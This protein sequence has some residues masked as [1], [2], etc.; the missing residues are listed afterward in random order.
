M[1]RSRR[2]SLGIALVL[3]GLIAALI[4]ATPAIATST[5]RA[6]HPRTSAGMAQDV[7]GGVVLFGGLEFNNAL[8]DT[9]RWD[10]RGWTALHPAHSPS[11]RISMGMAYDAADGR[12]VLFGGRVGSQGLGDTWTW[13]GADW[14]QRLGGSLRLAPRSG[15]AG[16]T[17][18]IQGWG[19]AARERVQLRFLDSVQGNTL[20]STL[21]SDGTG[22]FAATVTIP[23]GA[24]LGKQRVKARGV[25]SGQIAKAPYRVK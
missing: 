23:A 6:P 3:T 19:F 18:L 13:D 20:L 14:T 24:T 10:E 21:H 7:T 9:W 5:H 2:T 15:H 4:P 22:A 16:D 25:R 12:V 11:P 17:V 1:T 8:G